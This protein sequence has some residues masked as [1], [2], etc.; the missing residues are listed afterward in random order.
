[1]LKR[2]IA[3]LSI[4]VFI[5][6]GCGD[7]EDTGGSDGDADLQLFSAELGELLVDADGRTVYLFVPDTQDGS[8]CYNDCEAAWPPLGELST[9]G[10][11]L[12]D[13][14]LGTTE[15]NNGD[16]QATYN[17]WPLYHF[18]A[19]VEPGDTK[20]QGANDVWYVIDAEGEPIGRS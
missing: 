10:E 4:T 20:G 11:G 5:A 15:R 3:V 12:D 8:T 13:G 14:L 7:D 17:G 6:A 9:A 16:A 19:D 1:M 18:S 2:L